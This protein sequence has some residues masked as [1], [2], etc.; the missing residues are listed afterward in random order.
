VKGIGSINSCAKRMKGKIEVA[1]LW[2]RGWRRFIWESFFSRFSFAVPH[3][4]NNVQL[5]LPSNEGV[6]RDFG[7]WCNRWVLHFWVCSLWVCGGYSIAIIVAFECY[8]LKTYHPKQP[9]PPNQSILIATNAFISYK[10]FLVQLKEAPMMS[11]MPKISR[12]DAN[13]ARPLRV[14][15]RISS[16]LTSP[17]S[18]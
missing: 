4:S 8:F 13:K 17:E 18:T 6:S 11:V 12:F 1:R 16:G 5:I 2:N 9:I 7:H 10:T 3:T 14:G 15:S